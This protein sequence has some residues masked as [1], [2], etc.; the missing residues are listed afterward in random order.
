MNSPMTGAGINVVRSSSSSSREDLCTA[1]FALC[2]V[3]R[4]LVS[5]IVGKISCMRCSKSSTLFGSC[6][7]KDE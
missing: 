7:R 2:C 4:Y 3:A 5:M 1:G 6:P